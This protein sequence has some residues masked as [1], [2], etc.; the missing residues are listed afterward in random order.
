MKCYFRMPVIL[1]HT[2]TVVN[3]F[4]LWRSFENSTSFYVNLSHRVRNFVNGGY[5]EGCIQVLEVIE[6]IKGS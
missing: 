3:R 2:P 5:K 1:N 6:V 4:G